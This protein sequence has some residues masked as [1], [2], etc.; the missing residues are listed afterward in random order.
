MPE[1]RWSGW[2]GAWCLDCG[3]DDPR[4][5]ALADGDYSIDD[6]TG[7]PIAN[8]TPEQL[9]CSEPGSNRNNPYGRETPPNTEPSPAGTY[10][11]NSELTELVGSEEPA[12]WDDIVYDDLP[13]EE[14]DQLPF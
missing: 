1:C 4:E 7:M 2:P 13:K 6:A 3:R 8:V 11:F 9:E 14:D 12:S 5:I 10:G